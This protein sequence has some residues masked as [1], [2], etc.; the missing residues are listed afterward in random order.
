MRIAIDIGNSTIAFGIF[1]KKENL[2]SFFKIKK[3]ELDEGSIAFDH[4]KAEL[5][6]RK[7]DI[8]K[9]RA[10]YISSVAPSVTKKLVKVLKKL[11]SCDIKIL[12]L[13]TSPLIDDK[14]VNPELGCDIYANAVAAKYKHPD[15]DIMLVDFG[16][17]S[18]IV[19][20]DRKG[21]IRGVSIA[22][23]FYTSLQAICNKAELL[24]SISA[25]NAKAQLGNTTESAITSGAVFSAIGMVEAALK[26]ATELF[27]TKPFV[28]ATGGVSG[29]INANCDIID[30]QDE[31]NTVLGVLKCLE[32]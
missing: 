18:T 11:F 22:A 28:I 4:L 20:V 21:C 27:G 1:E 17:A 6:F 7:V 26:S 8:E 2:K 29:L 9:V 19:A 30:E 24:G 15:R 31:Y 10:L 23:G 16:T 32:G 13:C 14:T 3:D 12:A 5:S 25:D